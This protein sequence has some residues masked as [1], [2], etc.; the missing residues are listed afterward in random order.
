MLAL[1]FKNNQKMSQM[2]LLVTNVAELLTAAVQEVLQLM[3][4]AVSE[5]QKETARTRLENHNLQ[6]KLKELQ[7]QTALVSGMSIFL[8]YALCTSCVMPV[9]FAYFWINS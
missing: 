3:G 6:M 7:V 4:Q 9:Y 2:D 5:Y 1:F 8:L